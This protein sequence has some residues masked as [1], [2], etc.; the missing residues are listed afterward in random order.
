MR[1]IQTAISSDLCIRLT[2]NL[3]GTSWVVSYGCK[4]IPRWRTAAIW[5]SIYRHI[6]VK[7]LPCSGQT[8]SSTERISCS[9]TTTLLP[10][11]KRTRQLFQGRTSCGGRPSGWH[12]IVTCQRLV[13]KHQVHGFLFLPRD[14][15]HKRG[16]CRHAVSVCP[17]I[18]LTVT[19][20]SCAK[21]NKDIFEIFSLSGSQAI[22]VF[23]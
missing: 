19:F 2:W 20:M 12:D 21:T 15:M 13:I 18:C 10:S 8:P 14:A 16:Y 6:S 5:K 23:P 17:S 3:T 1:K 4:T 11:A 7:N 9:K 22:L